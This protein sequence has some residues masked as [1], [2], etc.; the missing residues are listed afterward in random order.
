MVQQHSRAPQIKQTRRRLRL[1]QH[2]TTVSYLG[3]AVVVA[4]WLLTPPLHISRPLGIAVVVVWL[5][6]A[7]AA[8]VLMG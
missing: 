1:A 2:L 4:W 3:F 5:V 6:T 7:M 8:F